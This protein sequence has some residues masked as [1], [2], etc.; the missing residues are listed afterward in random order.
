MNSKDY[1]EL[2]EKYGAHNYHP[3][4][5]VISWAEGVRVKDPEGKSYFDFLSAYSAVNQGHRHPRIIKALVDQASVCTLTSRAFHNDKMGQ[6]LQK[7]CEYTGYEHALPMNTGAEAVET[8]I[9]A[10]RR[11][12]VEVKG[13]DNGNQEIVCVK[14]NFHGRT[15][16]AITMSNDPDSTV[17][18]GPY[19]P[20][21]VRVPYEDIDAMAAAINA[22]TV[23]VIL[24]PIQ[25]EAGVCV[26]YEGY[27]AAVRA[28][29]TKHQVLF[30]C[31]E[32]QTGF[33]RTGKRFAWM[34]EDAR[35]DIMCLGKA[36]GGGV[37]PVSAIVADHA[38]MQVF[39]PGTHGSTFG[40]N[41]LAS[42][43][44]MAALDVLV[45]EKLDEHAEAM[46]QI[47]RAELA[48][49][50]CKNMV[51][52]RGKGL[53]NAVL[54]KDGFQAWDVCLALRDAGLLAKQ[55]HGNIIRFAP[56]LV[57]TEAE[58]REAIAIIKGVLVK[59]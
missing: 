1:I 49:A 16:A 19:V 24:E 53:L 50:V 34:H 36:L 32:V 42:A 17:N 5:V 35:P 14:E 8:A 43:V 22:N 39:T 18:Y 48:G 44:A 13:V 7:L 47:F 30:I 38:V 57:I 21:F 51:K 6:Y 10:A 25:G 29:C 15:L 20:G 26:P 46:G 37:F 41:P 31:D 33:C 3:L 40:G 28:L 59:Y 45:D 12:G 2:D 27:L 9:K 58:L 55:T 23:A 54:F 52:V 56:P 4:P 11:W